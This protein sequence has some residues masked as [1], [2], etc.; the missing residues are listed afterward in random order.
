MYEETC[1][2]PKTW[3]SAEAQN[4]PWKVLKVLEE[5]GKWNLDSICGHPP[6]SQSL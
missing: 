5:I 1:L 4:P 3:L 2:L 6:P